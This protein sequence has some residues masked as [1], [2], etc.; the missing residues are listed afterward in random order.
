MP[1]WRR[2]PAAHR[3]RRTTAR[4][5]GGRRTLE[6]PPSRDAVWRGRLGQDSTR[7]SCLRPNGWVGYLWV[8]RSHGGGDIDAGRAGVRTWPR[9]A[10]RAGTDRLPTSGRESSP[11]KRR[12]C[13][14]FWSSTTVNT[15]STR[16]GSS[17][18]R[19][20]H[21]PVVSGCWR[22]HGF[23]SRC[24]QSVS[25]RCQHSRMGQ[26]SSAGA[27]RSV[28]CPS[29]GIACGHR[30]AKSARPVDELP[31]AIEIAAAQTPYRTVHEIADEL[32]LGIEHRVEPNGPAAPNP[33]QPPSFGVATFST[34]ML[35]MR[36]SGSVSSSTCSRR[37]MPTR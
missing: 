9:P 37:T 3:L 4:T 25:I 23:P 36:S 15:W 21:A 30:G 7:S 24:Q 27:R 28:V 32:Q 33:W 35:P 29:T 17:S 10:A 22:P 26:N 2:F 1:R 18:R 34:S 20:S 8:R 19:C 11:M 5:R 13:R 6:R 31:L 12:G 14:A 16:F